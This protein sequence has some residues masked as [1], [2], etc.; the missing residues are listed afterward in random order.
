VTVFVI[1]RQSGSKLKVKYFCGFTERGFDGKTSSPIWRSKLDDTTPEGPLRYPT[2]NHA[3]IVVTEVL[4]S[5]KKI[6]EYEIVEVEG[7]PS[8]E[9]IPP[10]M[11]DKES[12]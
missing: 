8:A 4:G 1:S 9:V 10:W 11:K 2:R 6:S 3:L 5:P 12:A 7:E